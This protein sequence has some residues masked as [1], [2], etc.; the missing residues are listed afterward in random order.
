MPESR[1]EICIV[2]AGP[3]GLAVL[4]RICAAAP[5]GG[6]ER[7]TVHLVDPRPPGG[8][9]WRTDQSTQLLMN[10]V[11]AQVTV[12]T[13]ESVT[14]TGP[15]VPGPSLYEWAKT[16]VLGDQPT[17]HPHWVRSEAARL[18]ADSYPSRAFYGHYLG[19]VH[20]HLVRTA[21]ATVTVRRHRDTAVEL[22]DQPDG[23]QRLRL[24]DGT[25]LTD[26]D[27]VVLAQG[28][29]PLALGSTERRLADYAAVNGLGYL[30]P[31]N[32]ADA[33]LSIARPGRPVALRG[34][35]LNFFD[36]LALLTTGRGGAFEEFDGRLVYRPCGDE[37]VIHAGSRRG[38]PFHA[39]GDNQK[40][41]SGRHLPLFLTPERIAELTLRHSAHGDLEFTRDLWPLVDREVRGVYYAALLAARD[42]LAAR[43]A[44]LAEY[45][46]LAADPAAL[47]GLLDRHGVAE[48]DHWSWEAIQRPWGDLEF[49]Q[50][51]DFRHWLLGHLHRDIREAA[52]GNALGPLKAALDVLRDLR[53]ELRLV[54]DHAGL[55]GR[56]YRDELQRWY[57][58]LNGFLSIGPPRR[59]IEELTALIE[60]GVLHPIGPGMTV[61]EAGDGD[62]FLVSS[63]LVPDS[64]VRVEA[65]IEARLPEPD[66]RHT[67]DPLL[68]RL[69]ETGQCRPYLIPDP[70]GA[71]Y[72]TGG[73][74]VT[75]SPYRLVDALGE[76][77]PRRFAFGV[78]TEAVHWVTAAG[79]RPGVNSVIL[80]D[81]DAIAQAVLAIRPA[82][83]HQ[84]A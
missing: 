26:L 19:W 1:Q 21:P 59:R 17:E 29:L 39:R 37:P 15:I 27:A 8:A 34:L 11:A 10:T 72:Q 16:I 74:A 65:L 75:R 60:A 41:V 12:F 33:D 81:A 51:A 77:H 66:L 48:A 23:R 76:V 54:V 56:S 84:P 64:E 67:T 43:E 68:T 44:F 40:G 55:T 6:P 79:V 20:D 47:A 28:H 38:V 5:T 82:E 53:N 35:G 7:T 13:D 49:A 42:G 73:L 45:V 30:P 50:P 4:E 52:R 71:G 36:H 25:E 3:R 32:P 69:R 9:V 31:G 2:G 57:S 61:T 78:P 14:A 58:P 70:D 83:L 80:C 62:G 18:T 63:S 22:T 46:P 24:A